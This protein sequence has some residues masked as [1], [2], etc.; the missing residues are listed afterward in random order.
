METQEQRKSRRRQLTKRMLI[1]LAVVLVIF[2]AIFGY[3]AFKTAMGNKA[4]SAGPPPASVSTT[5]AEYRDWQP[6]LNAVGTLRAS[7]GVDLSTEM[8][9]IVQQV[10]FSSG[11]DVEQGRVLIELNTDADTAQLQSLKAAAELAKTVYERDKQQYEIQAVSKAALDAA[12]ADLKSKQALVSQQLAVI[13]KK[14]ILA[15]F[16]GRAGIS[17]VNRGQYVNP[18]DKLVTIQSLDSILIDF[19]VPQQDLSRISIG[20]RARITTDAL[21]GRMFDGTITAINPKVDPET[22]NVQVEAKIDNPR[23]ELLPGMFAQVEIETGKPERLLTL[24]QTAVTYN[25]YGD[26]VFVVQ[27]HEAPGKKQQLTVK[28]VFVTLGPKRGDQVAILKGVGEGDTVVTSGQLKLKNESPIVV[29]NRVQPSNEPA[30][31]PEEQ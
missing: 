6:R 13:R 22:R 10:R 27:G 2:A 31:K 12:A 30:P 21:P 23:H 18:G 19:L 16:R 5:K 24:P 8:A 28:Q 7:R 4:M 11:D 3:K 1:M 9:G 26:T 25:P 29:N 15:P 17:T 14:R 20:Q